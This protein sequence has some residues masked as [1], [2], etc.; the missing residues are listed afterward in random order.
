[1][2]RR[3]EVHPDSPT[4]P[5]FSPTG[6]SPEFSTLTP[7]QK[8]S[9]IRGLRIQSSRL[10]FKSEQGILAYRCSMTHDGWQL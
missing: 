1:V 3:D 7:L 5:W 8:S 10:A 2:Q 4:P 6:L 9:L